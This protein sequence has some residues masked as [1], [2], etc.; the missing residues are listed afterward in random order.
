LPALPN[1]GYAG[2][3]APYIKIQYGGRDGEMFLFKKIGV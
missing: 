1:D 2:V 3:T